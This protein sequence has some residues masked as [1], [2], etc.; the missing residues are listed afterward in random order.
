[1]FC[2]VKIYINEKCK[3]IKAIIDTGNF[4]K[5]P[6]TKTPVIVVEK[7]ALCSLIPDY[8][9]ENIEKIIIGGDIDLGEYISKIRIIPFTSLGKQNG[10]LLG[11]KADKVLIDI[12]E[13]ENIINN[14][15]IGIYNEKLTKDG[16]YRALVGI[17][18]LERSEKTYE[19]I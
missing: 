18:L 7:E 17:E 13:N 14:I 5:E 3:E 15:I 6:I 9:L 19:Y 12:G 11:I 2:L 16:K 8:I 4:L 10:V 1:M